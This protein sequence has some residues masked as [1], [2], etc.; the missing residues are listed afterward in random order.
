MAEGEGEGAG[1]G[2]RSKFCSGGVSGWRWEAMACCAV[3][4]STASRVALVALVVASTR[5][6]A[7]ADQRGD[8]VDALTVRGSTLSEK[9]VAAGLLFAFRECMRGCSKELMQS[10]VSVSAHGWASGAAM[11]R[12]DESDGDGE[13]Q[14]RSVWTRPA[15][16]GSIECSGWNGWGER[17]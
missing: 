8:A 2:G 4:A 1:A 12:A 10:H 14:Q 5:S 9:R 17:A 13:Q 11:R 7:S 3:S 16:T 15:A 6:G